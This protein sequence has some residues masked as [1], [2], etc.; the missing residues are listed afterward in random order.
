MTAPVHIR[1]IGS[2]RLNLCGEEGGQAT[3]PAAATCG[4][5]RAVYAE[6][7]AEAPADAHDEDAGGAA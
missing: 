7:V 1:E 4:M 3:F 2:A 6:E 5:C